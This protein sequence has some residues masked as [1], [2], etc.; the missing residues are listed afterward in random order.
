M[1]NATLAESAASIP[2]LNKNPRAVA[3]LLK[4]LGPRGLRLRDE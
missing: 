2:E 4:R 3:T 1:A